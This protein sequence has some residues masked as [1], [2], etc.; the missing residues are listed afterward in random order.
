ML[1]TITTTH[2]PATDLGY[3]LRKNPTR[4]QTTKIA[5]GD[6]HIFYPEATQN[7]CTAAILVEIDPIGMIRGRKRQRSGLPLD[8]YVNDRPYVSSSFLC[9]ALAQVFGSAMKGKCPE[10]PKLAV[11]PIPLEIGLDVVP[12]RDGD[13]LITRL[14]EPLGYDVLTKRLPLDKKF[15][16]WGDSPYFEVTL[17]KKSRLSDV[18]N[19][20]YVLI[21]VLDNQ[22]H[23]YISDDEINKLIERGS[24]WLASHP[25]YELIT[26]RYLKYKKNLAFEALARLTEVDPETIGPPSHKASTEEIQEQAIKLNEQRVKSTID[27]L[28]NAGSRRILDLGCGDGKLLAALLEDRSFT[29]ILRVLL[30]E[31]V[32]NVYLRHKNPESSCIRDH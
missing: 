10:R 30:G 8:Q 3:L 16:E 18:L 28:N 11:A 31:Y 29:E 14:F 22:K 2:V 32:M 15:V 5:F 4:C 1:L 17:R 20:L 19:H 7:R 23:Y 21:P 25:Q 6:V 26:R 12:S 24:G 27:V 13:N 9:V